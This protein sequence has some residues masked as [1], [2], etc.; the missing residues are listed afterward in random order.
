[1][2]RDKTTLEHM[3]LAVEA[4]VVGR[5]PIRT[6]LQEAEPHFGA[7][8]DSE[9]NT[10]T[11]RELCLGIGAA[12]VEGGDEDDGASVFE[13]IAAL[14]ETRAIETARDMLRLFE[15]LAGLRTDNGWSGP[16]FADSLV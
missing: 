16:A 13:S 9:M 4:L 14:D 1:M 7:V 11:E 12:L 2:Q 5:G 10:R 6:R 3:R 15:L 8:I